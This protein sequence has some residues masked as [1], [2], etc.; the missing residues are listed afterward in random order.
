M[1]IIKCITN[2]WLIRIMIIKGRNSGRNKITHSKGKFRDGV[3]IKPP[4]GFELKSLCVIIWT[5]RILMKVILSDILQG[6]PL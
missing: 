6:E 2:G 4:N 5:Y 1:F 3:C